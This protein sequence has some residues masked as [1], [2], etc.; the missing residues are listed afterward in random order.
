MRTY[1]SFMAAEPEPSDGRGGCTLSIIATDHDI[2]D[3]TPVAAQH[4][5]CRTHTATRMLRVPWREQCPPAATGTH[6]LL[7]APALQGQRQ[8]TRDGEAAAGWR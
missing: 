3:D 8:A 7:T 4:H 2:I 5:A 1:M 6:H